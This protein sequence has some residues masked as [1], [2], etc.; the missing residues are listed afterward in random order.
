M[1]TNIMSVHSNTVFLC[2]CMLLALLFTLYRA[3]ALYYVLYSNFGQ[4]HRPC[5]RGQPGQATEDGLMT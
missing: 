4:Y 2:P 3:V 1:S 5:A